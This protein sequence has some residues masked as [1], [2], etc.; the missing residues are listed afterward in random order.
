MRWDSRSIGG[1]SAVAGPRR[2]SR[3]GL[4]RPPVT[5][6]GVG[7]RKPSVEVTLRWKF[8]GSSSLRHTA[9]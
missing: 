8:R 2:N 6:V 3:G 1:C 4:P 7:T 5:S 9:S